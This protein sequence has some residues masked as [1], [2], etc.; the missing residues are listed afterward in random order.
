MLCVGCLVSVTVSGLL[1]NSQVRPET[2]GYK[3]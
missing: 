1:Q 2:A 3:W